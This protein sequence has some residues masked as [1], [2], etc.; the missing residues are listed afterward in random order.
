MNK[1]FVFLLENIPCGYIYQV[2]LV[3]WMNL[4]I[5][6]YIIRVKNKY[7]SHTYEILHYI[8]SI[9]RKNQSYNIIHGIYDVIIVYKHTS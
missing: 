4:Y 9:C 5:Y 6:I 3:K 1:N 2:A 7:I 8:Y